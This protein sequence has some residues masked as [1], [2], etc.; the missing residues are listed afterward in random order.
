MN[1]F[2]A[3]WAALDLFDRGGSVSLRV[4]SLHDH[5][6]NLQVD[7]WGHMLM[8]ADP[9][10]YRGPASIGLRTQDFQAIKNCLKPGDAACFQ[11]WKMEFYGDSGIRISLSEAER[12]SFSVPSTVE[13]D[14]SGLADS[15][16][17]N[18]MFEL[19]AP[20]LCTCL[21]ADTGGVAIDPFAETIA[22]EFPLLIQS[23]ARG[24]QPGF[25]VAA[26]SLIGLGYGST[27]T[28]DDLIHGALIA[29][30]FIKRATRNDL[31][32]PSLPRTIAARTTLLG[33]HMLEM[34]KLGLTAEP[35]RNFALNLL[36][37]KPIEP[38]FTD[39]RRMGSDSGCSIAV[40]FY[41]MVLE[42]ATEIQGTIVS[43]S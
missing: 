39:L 29:L 16:I 24:S 38:S 28:G 35:V 15:A 43:V 10:M 37:G 2:L 40:G 11:D 31:P 23:L 5:V 34:G 22:C 6:M 19:A 30:H 9:E 33:S 12:V 42:F 36:A 14:G 7:R 4:V 27:P 3:A 1:G 26:S 32:I 13:F 17:K 8:L 41:L 20:H 18:A 25:E 21:L